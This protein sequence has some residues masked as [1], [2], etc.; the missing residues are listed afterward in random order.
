MFRTDPRPRFGSAACGPGTILSGH[1]SHAARSLGKMYGQHVRYE[2][3]ENKCMSLGRGN[4]L[5]NLLVEK[6]IS[7]GGKRAKN[8]FIDSVGMGTADW[9][10]F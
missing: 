1:S 8:A 4:K 9:L 6:G 3:W 10:E 2:W 7:V 5:I